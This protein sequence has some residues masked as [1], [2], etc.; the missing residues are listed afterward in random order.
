[1][2]IYLENEEAPAY[3][4]FDTAYHLLDSQNRAYARANSGDATH[5]LQ[6]EHGQGLV[7]VLTDA[8]LWRNDSIASYD[9]AWLLW[10]L[11]QDSA[12]TLIHNA[13]RDGLLSQL[14]EHYPAALTALALLLALLLWHV[15]LR[16][17]P[18]QEQPTP[19]RRQ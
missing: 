18:L 9:N 4:E 14:L 1:T 8:W 3:V 7:T 16:H 11:T 5:M 17:G 2:K 10:Y 15:G 12:V 13:E 19:A 6:L